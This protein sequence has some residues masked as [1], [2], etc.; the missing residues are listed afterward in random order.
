MADMK[1]RRVEDIPFY[2]GPGAIE[3]IKFRTA[4][5]ELGVSAWGMNVLE[6]AAGVTG[7][8]QHDHAKDGQ[9]EVY[10]VLEG[11]GILEVAGT[12]TPLAAGTLV[13]VGPGETRKIIPGEGGIVVLAIGGT[14]GQAYPAP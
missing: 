10:A 6:I 1:A 2:Q 13:R 4:G 8:P 14:P 11:G 5:R 3:G 9:E 12:R 7:Y